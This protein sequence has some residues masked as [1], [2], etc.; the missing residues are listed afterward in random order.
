MY[1]FLLLDVQGGWLMKRPRRIEISGNETSTST[2]NLQVSEMAYFRALVWKHVSTEVCSQPPESTSL[3]Q[4]KFMLF[5]AQAPARPEDPTLSAKVLAA[6]PPSPSVIDCS[7]LLCDTV[8]D[9][10]AGSAGHQRTSITTLDSCGPGARTTA[11]KLFTPTLPT[12]D[13]YKPEYYKLNWHKNGPQGRIDDI[14]FGRNIDG[15]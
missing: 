13:K 14:K 15:A 9:S 10:T 11:G 8:R 6:L 3:S 4:P 2:A 7:K 12:V 5:G 1:I